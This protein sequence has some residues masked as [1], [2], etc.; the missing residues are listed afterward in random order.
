MAQDTTQQMTRHH[1]QLHTR[2]MDD[3]EPDRC[4]K[5]TFGGGDKTQEIGRVTLDNKRSAFPLRVAEKLSSSMRSTEQNSFNMRARAGNTG[6]PQKEQES[7]FKSKRLPK[8]NKNKLSPNKTTL[9]DDA[10][11]LNQV[12]SPSSPTQ[13]G[14]RECEVSAGEI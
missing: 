6:P 4:N 7:E 9:R 12:S 14:W 11:G 13:G 1:T 2:G 5:Q 3:T 10:S 8:Y